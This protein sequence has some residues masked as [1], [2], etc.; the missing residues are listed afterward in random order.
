VPALAILRQVWIQ[1]YLCDGT[2]LRWREGDNIPPAA[3]FIS[4]PYDPEG[5]CRNFSEE[6][7]EALP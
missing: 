1:N 7:K 5:I 6:T 2:Q 3:Q 4:S